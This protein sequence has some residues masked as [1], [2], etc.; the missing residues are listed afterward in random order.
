MQPKRFRIINIRI[1][2][3]VKLGVSDGPDYARGEREKH[4]K[5]SNLIPENVFDNWE[6][7]TWA[8]N[9]KSWIGNQIDSWKYFA[10]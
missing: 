2:T 4:R 8:F 6:M 9:C 7:A 3:Y 1:H 5:I 10:S